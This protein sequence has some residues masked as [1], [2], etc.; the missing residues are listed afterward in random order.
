M[1][2]VSMDYLQVD[3]SAAPSPAGMPRT[4]ANVLVVIDHFTRYAYAI[5]TSSQSANTVAKE[6]YNRVFS[7]FG[8][9]SQLHSDQAKNFNSKVVKELC[10]I[11]HTMKSRTTVY[12]PQGNGLCERF[13]STLL[14]MIRTL[15]VGQRNRW[16]M[17]LPSLVY[18]YNATVQDT[19]KY[20]P[21]YLMFGRHP[22]LPM[23][24]CLAIEQDI[25]H[26]DY[27]QYVNE[28][29]TSLRSAYEIAS[30]H[31]RDRHAKDGDRKMA[32]ARPHQLKPGDV[33][34]VK[35]LGP[36]GQSKIA[37]QWEVTPYVVD[38]QPDA[39]VPVY[40]VKPEKG[41]GPVRTLH[42]D[43]LLPIAL[44]EDHT[45]PHVGLPPAKQPRKLVNPEP[46]LESDESSDEEFTECL[47][48]DVPQQD[49]FQE[50]AS[51]DDASDDEDEV[52]EIE[53]GDGISEDESSDDDL[54]LPDGDP[55]DEDPPIP[56]DEPVDE[57]PPIPEDDVVEEDPPEDIEGVEEEP[58]GEPEQEAGGVRCS[59]RDNKGAPPDFYGERGVVRTS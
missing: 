28:L 46:V 39:D 32:K 9:P 45:A 37:T 13:N 8:F 58:E 52:Q 51:E 36:K 44:T 15:P 4:K 17:W 34:L 5:E 47:A 14:N 40:H 18:I 33:V 20:S 16:K 41:K 26:M 38:A 2:V 23:D 31:T 21:F 35:A 56:P 22:R 42:R 11:A 57:G 24:N 10:K 19:T 3:R 29:R 43:K 54:P 53:S 12:H 50:P 48:L 6:L 59:A 55:A 27:P 25:T 49:P 30:A 7:L 1:E